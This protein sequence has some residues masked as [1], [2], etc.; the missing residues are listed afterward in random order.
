VSCPHTA[1]ATYAWRQLDEK[2][3]CDHD[4]ILVATAHPAKFETIVEPIIGEKVELPQGLKELL[5]RPARAISIDP[6]VA[7]LAAAIDAF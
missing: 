1:T 6:T 7:A 5:A 2:L 3:K 4:W